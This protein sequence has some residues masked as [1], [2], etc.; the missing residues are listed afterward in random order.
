[1]RSREERREESRTV[2][3]REV[4]GKG[5]RKRRGERKERRGREEELATRVRLRKGSIPGVT[6]PLR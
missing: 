6:S 3:R 2:C 1:M 4:R 5:K